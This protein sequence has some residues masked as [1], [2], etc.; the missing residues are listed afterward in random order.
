MMTA[1]RNDVIKIH[2]KKER[3]QQFDGDEELRRSLIKMASD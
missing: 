3:E 1:K 2:L